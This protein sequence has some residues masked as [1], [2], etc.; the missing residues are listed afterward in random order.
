MPTH[1][2]FYPNYTRLLGG[3]IVNHDTTGRALLAPPDS[4]NKTGGAL[5]LVPTS[6]YEA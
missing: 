4:M 6:P 3:V 5:P 2:V 1:W